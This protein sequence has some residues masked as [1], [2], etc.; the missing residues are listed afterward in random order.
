MKKRDLKMLALLGLTSGLLI[1]TPGEATEQDTPI[2]QEFLSSLST[3]DQELFQNLDHDGQV[4]AK[5]IASPSCGDSSANEWNSRN[6]SGISYNNAC[7]G[8]SGCGGDSGHGSYNTGRAGNSVNTYQGDSGARG[9]GGTRGS[10]VNSNSNSQG[11]GT[12]ANIGGNQNR[13][14]GQ[15]SLAEDTN[16]YRP[17]NQSGVNAR[18]Q[19][20]N[21]NGKTAGASGNTGVRN[22]A[23]NNG[24]IGNGNSYNNAN[25][26]NANY[27]NSNNSNSYNNNSNYNNSNNSNSNNG[28]NGYLAYGNDNPRQY[29]RPSGL[30]SNANN[31]TNSN[32]DNNSN[33]NNSNN[34]RSF[35]NNAK[36]LA[37]KAN[38][39]AAKVK[40]RAAIGSEQPQQPQAI[41]R[42]L[43]L[44][45]LNK[46][47][48]A[49]WYRLSPQGQ[50]LA[51]ELANQS[52]KG[53][54]ACEGKNA[55]SNEFAAGP[56]Q[57]T[58]AGK[59][60]GPFSDKNLAVRVAAMHDKRLA[61]SD[62]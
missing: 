31:N 26:N 62:N 61:L 18:Q 51:L 19:T 38:Q 22:N 1:S 20:F 46:Q 14:N 32:Y 44:S 40:N 11:S 42:E 2:D 24:R 52:C 15:V 3:E 58:C 10:R 54:N 21:D 25:Y 7:G 9:Q 30:T 56:G 45:L 34:S 35:K 16:T 36:S 37:E 27:N 12:N 4:L 6:G 13:R 39:N 57:G 5:L 28:E 48:K 50:A 49:Q 47:G 41:D 8:K 17:R 29:N 59:S 33:N 55:C 43:L 53:K 60:V 23:G